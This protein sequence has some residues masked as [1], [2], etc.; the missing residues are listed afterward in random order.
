[1][2]DL[3]GHAIE[4]RLCAEDPAAAFL[5]SAGPVSLFS[6][7]REEGVRVDSGIETGD[8]ISPFYDSMVA[9]VIAWGETRETARLKL[10]SALQATALAGRHP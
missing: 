9:K 8:A 2:I 5:P 4:V 1:M 10:R 7:P 6:V 3:F